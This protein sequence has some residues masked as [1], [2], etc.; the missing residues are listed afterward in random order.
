MPKEIELIFNHKENN[1]FCYLHY[2]FLDSL[3]FLSNKTA[4]SND[5]CRKC[6]FL[7]FKTRVCVCEGGSIA[8]L[9]GVFL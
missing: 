3:V 4:L 1:W 5:K 9:G 6:W 2:K 8:M 7:V